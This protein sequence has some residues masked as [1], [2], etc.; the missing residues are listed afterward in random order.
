MS[1]KTE[2]NPVQS[3][4]KQ[5]F[6]M[7]PA[8]FLPGIDY[9][10]LNMVA[11]TGPEF[12]NSV[13][14]IPNMI[15]EKVEY[16]PLFAYLFRRFG[17]PN[18]GWDD[19][20]ELTRYYL[21]T[22]L[23][24]M[25]LRVA[26][27][28]GDTSEITF[29]FLVP[30]SANRTIDNYDQ[31]DQQAYRQRMLDWIDANATIPAWMGECIELVRKDFNG[32]AASW[33]EAFKYLPL[34]SYDSKRSGR[35]KWSAWHDAIL[36]Q[37][38]AVEAVPSMNYRS[39]NY[40]E[41]PDDDPLKRYVQAA[42]VAFDDLKRSVRVRDGAI[43]AFGLANNTSRTLKE[44]PVAGWPSGDLGNAAPKEFSD[45]HSLVLKLGNGNAKRGIKKA[46]AV[47]AGGAHWRNEQRQPGMGGTGHQVGRDMPHDGR[48]IS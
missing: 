5:R 8:K 23:D 46:L 29:S 19:Y 7:K 22:P 1:S 11:Y 42:K 26:P 48:R 16:G 30:E 2:T 6:C 14:L 40:E 39:A 17:Y 10:G 36:K 32:Q 31:R 34:F 13:S 18:T 28:I 43:N 24:D 35:K 44:P 21:S 20:K 41:W 25:V 33:R 4:K 27:Y 9:S 45:L 38:A 15:G 3:R 12:G 47:L 37:Y